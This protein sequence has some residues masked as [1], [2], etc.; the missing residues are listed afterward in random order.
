MLKTDLVNPLY[1]NWENSLNLKNSRKKWHLNYLYCIHPRHPTE[2]QFYVFISSRKLFTERGIVVFI[3]WGTLN[4]KIRGRA[5]VYG[6]KILR[7][8]YTSDL[9]MFRGSPVVELKIF[10]NCLF[11]IRSAINKVALNLLLANLNFNFTILSYNCCKKK[12]KPTSASGFISLCGII[13]QE[14]REDMHQ[15]QA[16]RARQLEGNVCD[17][18][19]MQFSNISILPPSCKTWVPHLLFLF[20][21]L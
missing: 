2:E 19:P 14:F 16:T 1:R 4:T 3:Q 17:V 8:I 10:S 20:K 5:V 12:M 15:D 11:Q 6:M 18:F 9:S 13:Y 21:L 7:I